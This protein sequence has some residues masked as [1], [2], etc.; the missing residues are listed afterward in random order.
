MRRLLLPLLVPLAWLGF[1]AT[2]QA[3]PN[4]PPPITVIW[5]ADPSR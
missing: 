2:A 5:P 4:P 1:A 3:T